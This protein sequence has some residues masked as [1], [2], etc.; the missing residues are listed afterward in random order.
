MGT[1]F[2]FRG[3]FFAVEDENKEENV[4]SK[5][6]EKVKTI[7]E[8]QRMNIKQ[9]REEAATRGISASGTKKELVDRLCNHSNNVSSDN[10]PGNRI[11]FYLEKSILH[12]MP[13]F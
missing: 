9:L 10:N 6:P 8:L 12:P 11:I 2:D 7:D 4:D 5:V 3:I 1:S 13:K